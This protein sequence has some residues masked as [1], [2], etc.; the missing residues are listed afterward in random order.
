MAIRKMTDGISGWNSRMMFPKNRYTLRCIEED[1]APSKGGN[2]MLVR[3]WEIC[4]SEPVDIGDK[5][6]DIDGLTITQYVVT[7]VKNEDGDGWDASKSDK[8]FGRFADDLR[9]CGFP[10]DG[11]IDDENP[12]KFMLGKVVDAIVY[13]KENISYQSPTAEERAQGKKVGA[14]IKT[15]DGKDV[16][17]VQL[18]IDQILGLSTTE[19]NHPY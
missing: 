2:P 10:E 15:A 11:E 3:K 8:A 18:N 17:V 1:F 4:Q 19:V 7:K 9:L 5:K 6:V 16:K 13:G 12:P 14:A